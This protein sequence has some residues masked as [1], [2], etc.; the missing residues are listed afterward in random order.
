[1]ARV[2]SGPGFFAGI[3]LWVT[4]GTMY[5]CLT[6]VFRERS[7]PELKQSLQITG[8]QFAFSGFGVAGAVPAAEFGL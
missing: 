1:M 5:P 4:A 8:L 3:R 7:P 2:A 6:E